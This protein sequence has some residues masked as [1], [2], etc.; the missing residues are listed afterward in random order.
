MPEVSLQYRT[1]RILNH[2]Y[3]LEIFIFTVHIIAL[4]LLSSL[5]I[6]KNSP[7]ISTVGLPLKV[8]VV[9]LF[10]PIHSFIF[11]ASYKL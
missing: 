4:A 8:C 3:Y 2:P 5:K 6:K 7:Q 10:C 9:R 11:H 1:A